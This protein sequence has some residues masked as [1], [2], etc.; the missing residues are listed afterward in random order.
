VPERPAL[1]PN[2]HLVGELQGSG[3]TERQW[4]I[5]RDG[6]Y[7]QLTELLYRIA[8]HANG[9]RTLEQ[10]AAA[11]T[12]A[13]EWLVTADDVR[14]LIQT[15][16]TPLGLVATADVP[17]VAHGRPARRDRGRSPLELDLCLE[18]L[19][20]RL[21]DPIARV[22][23][24]FFAPP[25]LV[26]VLLVLAVAHGWLYFV[27]GAGDSIRAAL[28]TPTGLLVALA[29]TIVAAVFHE[30]G[31]AAALR[32][33]GGRAG[34]IGAGLYVVWPAFYTDTT[35]S[36]RLGR[37]ARVRT[38]LGGFYFHLIFALG[39]IAL[40]AV[41]GHELLPF[42]VLLI[43]LGILYQLLPFVRLDGY[44]V[45]ADLVGIPDFFSQM[46]PFVRS[47]LPAT[48]AKG[49]RLP[50]LKPWVKAVFA[51]YVIAA[52]PALA[53]LYFLIVRGVPYLTVTAWN[54]WLHQGEVFDA[55]RRAGD[56]PTA[57]A[58]VTQMVLLALPVLATAYGL[59]RLGRRLLGRLWRWGRPTPARRLAA[60]LGTAG[61]VGLVA[62]LWTPGPDPLGLKR[63]A[64]P[65]GV[66]SFVVAEGRHVPT[67]VV[68]PQ[69]PPVGGDHAPLWQNCGFYDVPI[70]S[71]HAVHSL[72]HGAV[73][74]TYRPDLAG[75]QVAALRRLARGQTHVLV[76]PF[77]GLPAPVVASAWGRQ[78]RLEAADDP[79]LAQFVRVFRLGPQAPERG[80]PCVGG[81]GDA[82]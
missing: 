79:R 21:I 48:A 54:G 44:W 81:V 42:I 53:L 49:T 32:Y 15:K 23:Q 60:A 52:L 66:Q 7:I 73:W 50:A 39:T 17:C 9:E 27:H 29:L 82:R 26:A 5:Q 24:V 70:A 18:V 36:Y 62:F 43:D 76:S 35:D 58:A 11:V 59:S 77:P 68:Y 65:A 61:A 51:A 47:L 78:L 67:P 34:G 37:W 6:R 64:A 28:I 16:L 74:I 20:P 63:E 33:G 71:E 2:V 22:L 80:G 8:E 40:F 69:T 3:F 25:L 1:A 31:H 75:E 41:S 46:G 56:V 30:F 14:D 38:G 13:T 10:I 19:G 72:E 12:E 55:A 57:A 45:L 4:L